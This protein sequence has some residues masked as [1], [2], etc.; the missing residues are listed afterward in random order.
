MMYRCYKKYHSHYKYYGGRGVTVNERWHDFRNFVYDIDNVIE[1]GKL[2][3]LNGYQL[4][5]DTKGGKEYSVDNCV[6]LTAEENNRQRA[7]KRM[8]KV[9]AFNKEETHVFQ[10]KAEA[11]R[12]LNIPATSIKSAITRCSLHKKSGYY[13]KYLD[14]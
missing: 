7:E 1:N 5:K 8:K 12:Q 3:Y 2:L 4:D 9:M 11:S 6:V 13:F 10:S 14:L